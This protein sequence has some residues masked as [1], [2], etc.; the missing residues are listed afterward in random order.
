MTWVTDIGTEYLKWYLPKGKHQIIVILLPPKQFEIWASL[1]FIKDKFFKDVQMVANCCLPKSKGLSKTLN[2]NDPF[3][4]EVFFRY[5]LHSYQDE[6]IFIQCDNFWYMY[7]SWNSHQNKNCEHIHQT[8]KLLCNLYFLAF[9]F[10]PSP[11]YSWSTFC[12]YRSYKENTWL[13]WSINIYF[14]LYTTIYTTW[15]NL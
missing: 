1:I 4:L 12:H 11:V 5:N 3:V 9:M 10:L 15:G 7:N 13:S 6:Y 14:K 8:T 2:T